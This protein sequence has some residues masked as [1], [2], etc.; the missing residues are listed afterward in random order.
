MADATKETAPLEVWGGERSTGKAFKILA[1]DG[2][3]I[4]GAFAAS[5]LAEVER[6][7]NVRI[8]EHFDLV[9]GTSTGGLIAVAIAMDLPAE[10]IET[11]YRDHG[12]AIFTRRT[13]IPLPWWKGILAAKLDEH[14]AGYGLDVDGLLQSKYQA[15]ALRSALVDELGDRTLGEAR[16]RVVVPS[17]NLTAGQTKVFKT[18]H[19]PGLFEDRHL[20]AVEVILATTAAP[21]YFPH[22]TIGQADYSD[23]GLWANNPSMVALVEAG[24]VRKLCQR[25]GIDR[26]F[27]LP[28]IHLLSLGAGSVR[29]H[30]DPPAGGAGL[31]WWGPRLY[32]VLS[33]SQAQGVDFQARH[34]LGKDRYHRID[35]LPDDKTWSLDDTERLKQLLGLGEKSAVENLAALK[36]IF[37]DQK[38]KPYTPFPDIASQHSRA[39]GTPGVDGG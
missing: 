38:I 9:A 31:G 36:P 14:L 8:A 4:R 11:L 3:G 26:D 34:V 30:Y 13:Q 35:F 29:Y 28:D 15:E 2:G 27:A 19:L 6:R 39:D 16:T 22:A 10:R 24:L 32:E 1:L 12:E 21:T 18:P 17:V 33:I 7:L 25:P 20:S 23:G 37:F 5:F